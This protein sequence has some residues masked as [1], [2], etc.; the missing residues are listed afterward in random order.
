[1]KKRRTHSFIITVTFD[2]ACDAK[3][4]KHE[5]SENVHGEHYTNGSHDDGEPE[6]F[7]IRSI[8]RLPRSMKRA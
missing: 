6:E 8:K 7:R 2:R 4:A 1:M 5:V 3:F